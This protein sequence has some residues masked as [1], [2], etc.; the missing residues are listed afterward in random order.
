MRV[1]HRQKGI[2]R[3]NL[4]LTHGI[5]GR[6]MNAEKFKQ[7]FGLYATKIPQKPLQ[8]KEEQGVG[9]SILTDIIRIVP[10]VGKSH[11]LAI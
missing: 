6:K 3:W 8:N 5:G 4:R 11:L 2:Q 9:L 1:A 7:I 10:N